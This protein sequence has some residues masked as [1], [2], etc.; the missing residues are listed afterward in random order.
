LTEREVHGALC[1]AVI[2]IAVPIF[3][4]LFVTT[5]PYGRHAL[6]KARWT[7]PNHIGWLVMESP[8]VLVFGG[9]YALGATRAAPVSLVLLAA[10]MT[11]YVYRTFIFPLRLRGRGRPMPLHVVGMAVAFNTVNAYINARWISHLGGYNGVPLTEPRLV[12]GLVV[13]ITGWAINHRADAVLLALRRTRA[14]GEYAVPTGGLYR[15]VSCPNYLG[16]LIE[17]SGWALAAGS[18]AGLAFTVFTFANLAPRA[19]SHHRWYRATFPD[20]PPERRALVPGL[21]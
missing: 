5:A 15:W 1:V 8:T 14:D 12:G 17:W 6:P 18:L 16:E 7:L 3:V 4:A 11:H 13:M 2:A 21:W 19:L 10:W 20:Y 9:V